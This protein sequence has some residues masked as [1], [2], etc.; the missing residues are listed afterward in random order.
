MQGIGFFT[1]CSKK[2]NRRDDKIIKLNQAT[3]KRLML[4]I[5]RAKLAHTD[6]TAEQP[7]N[8]T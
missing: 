2:G 5:I 4:A 6:L 7:R 3:E 1:S 8:S